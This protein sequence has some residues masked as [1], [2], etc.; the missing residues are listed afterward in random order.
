M[1]RKDVEEAENSIAFFNEQRQ[2][3][4]SVINEVFAEL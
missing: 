2:N 4:L 3:Q 1:V